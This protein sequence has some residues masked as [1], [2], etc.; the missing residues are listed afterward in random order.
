MGKISRERMTGMNEEERIANAKS[1]G[2]LYKLKKS[3]SIKEYK[4]KLDEYLN[5]KQNGV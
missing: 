2:I 4:K 1:N 3:L 5:E